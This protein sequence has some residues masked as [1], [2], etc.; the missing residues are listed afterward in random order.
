MCLVVDMSVNCFLAS[1]D[2]PELMYK[3]SGY[4][5]FDEFYR[6]CN[7]G[8]RPDTIGRWD[9][10]FCRCFPLSLFLILCTAKISKVVKNAKVKTKHT[11]FWGQVKDVGPRA[12]DTN[13]A[14]DVEG[15]P[16]QV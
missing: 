10:R 15:E 12:D 3:A 16:L 7:R 1:G 8:L 2:M 5:D 9:L 13:S 11:R 4:R 6:D 14:F